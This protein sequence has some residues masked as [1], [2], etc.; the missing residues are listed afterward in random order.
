MRD[1]SDPSHEEIEESP[2]CAKVSCDTRES[3]NTTNAGHST[4]C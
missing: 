3:C 1:C 2:K 4:M